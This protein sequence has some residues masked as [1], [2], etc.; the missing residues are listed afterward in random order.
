MPLRVGNG[1]RSEES[2]RRPRSKSPDSLL[3]VE[4]FALPRLRKRF[5][6]SLML[7][8]LVRPSNPRLGLRRHHHRGMQVDASNGCGGSQHSLPT[9]VASDSHYSLSLSKVYFSKALDLKRSGRRFSADF[10]GQSQPTE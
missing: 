6:I 3:G 5:A 1:R 9:T 2:G 7:R 4:S 8:G 10:L